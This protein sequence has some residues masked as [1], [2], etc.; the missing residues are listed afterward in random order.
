MERN[1]KYIMALNI[2]CKLWNYVWRLPGDNIL[3]ISHSDDQN[4]SVVYYF[5][6]PDVHYHHWTREVFQ[7]F[8]RD[9][10][11]RGGGVSVGVLGGGGC[12]VWGWAK[13]SVQSDCAQSWHIEDPE[14]CIIVSER[15]WIILSGTHGQISNTIPHFSHSPSGKSLHLNCH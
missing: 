10:G 6:T 4:K 14:A 1:S 12:G 9:N 3:N 7:H 8:E 2:L 11:G 13:K 5:G 15:S